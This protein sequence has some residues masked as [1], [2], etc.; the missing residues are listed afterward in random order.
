MHSLPNMVAGVVQGYRLFLLI[1]SLRV[2]NCRYMMHGYIVH[3]GGAFEVKAT[4]I[5]TSFLDGFCNFV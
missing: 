1:V 4:M 5:Y 2:H 3:N